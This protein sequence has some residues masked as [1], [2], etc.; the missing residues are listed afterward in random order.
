MTESE[1]REL[2]V[3]SLASIA[4]EA[5]L[6][7]LAGDDSLRDELDLD[8]LDVLALATELSRRTGHEVLERDYPA[9]A[10]LDGA[11]ALVVARCTER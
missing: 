3:A 4:P 10:T 2:V 8:S 7:R 11:V 9:L 5:D 6:D 1:A